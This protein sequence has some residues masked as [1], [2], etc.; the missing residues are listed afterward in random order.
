MNKLFERY[1]FCGTLKEFVEAIDEYYDYPDTYSLAVDVM[2]LHHIYECDEID[3]IRD[4]LLDMPVRYY[5]RSTL[6]N[7]FI[8]VCLETAGYVGIIG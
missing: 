5:T 6:A 3:N 2:G 7:N 1:Y 8:T 4:D